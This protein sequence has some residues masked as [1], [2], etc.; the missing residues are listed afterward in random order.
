MATM[1]SPGSSLTII[2]AL[3]N[4]V[5]RCLCPSILC[6]GHGDAAWQGEESRV[7]T[8]RSRA[9]ESLGL[10]QLRQKPEGGRRVWLW[11]GA[12]PG[13]KEQLDRSKAVKQHEL[14]TK[15]SS[16][17]SKARRENRAD[18]LDSIILEI[19]FPAL[20]ISCPYFPPPPEVWHS[21]SLPS[22]PSHLHTGAQTHSG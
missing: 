3:Q 2:R 8:A 14:L 15:P 19:F 17:Y 6:A 18:Q 4:E 13:L 5:L 9:G 11:G 21:G 16:H 10:S 22:P 12:C 20:I 7:V 1:D